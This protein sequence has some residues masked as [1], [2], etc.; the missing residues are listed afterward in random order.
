MYHDYP[1]YTLVI[2]GKVIE[3]RADMNR[4]SEVC[5]DAH[6]LGF[7]QVTTIDSDGNAETILIQPAAE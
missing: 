3:E 5:S 1:T 2:N 6:Y 4:V 7:P